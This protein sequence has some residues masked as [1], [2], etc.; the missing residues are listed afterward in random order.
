MKTLSQV[1]A[2]PEQLPLISQNRTGIE[3]IYGAAGSGKTSTALLRLR[4]LYYMFIA[5]RER[6]NINKPIKILVLTYNRTLSGYIRTLTES[7]VN[8]NNNLELEIFTFAKWALSKLPPLTLKPKLAEAKL[9]ELVQNFGALT[10][11]YILKEVSYLLGRFETENLES[12]ITAERTGR[13]ILP[14]VDRHLR[15]KILD[16]IVYPYNNWLIENDYKDWNSLASSMIKEIIPLNYDIVV[17]DESQDFSANQLR[18]IRYHLAEDHTITFV[19]DTAQR[20]Y[21]RG[22][23]WLEAGY[24]VRPERITRLVTNYR[25]TVEIA[26]FASG[27]LQGINI[28]NDGALPN[29]TTASGHGE[30]P[31][32]LRGKYSK[33][34]SW[35][36]NYIKQNINLSNES[37][38]FLKPLAGNW[39]HIL[40]SALEE[41]DLEYVD[42]TRENVWPTGTEN[43]A[44]STFHSAKGLEFDYVFILGF[45]QQNT[46]FTTEE[47][48]DQVVV[49]RKLLAV[50]VARARKAVF[51]GYKPGEQSKLV[52]YFVP[53]SYI[54]ED[55]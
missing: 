10:K 49:L 14:R 54:L 45:N 11:E 16:E 42:I 39:F 44:L 24:D 4:S 21:A 19:M 38:V 18:A 22:F 1:I 12:Y 34:I 9:N 50:G 55:I 27:I 51:I 41:N 53:G 6:Q 7:Q 28:E 23:T 20:I 48:D 35:A 2:T 37:V 8:I 36:I 5:K 26:T 29:L 32:I 30:M 25:N 47:M 13:G 15:R 43:I 46:P 52:E 33:Q 31:L 40:Q 17:V 3:V